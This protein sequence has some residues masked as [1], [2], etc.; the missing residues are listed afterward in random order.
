MANKRGIDCCNGCVAPK[1]HIGCHGTC[2]EYK[3]AKAAYEQAKANAFAAKER[4]Q[5]PNNFLFRNRPR[6]DRTKDWK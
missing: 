2:K 4:M 5:A 6:K 3:A 1:R